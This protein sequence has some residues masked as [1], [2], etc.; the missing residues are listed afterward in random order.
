MDMPPRGVLTWNSDGTATP[1]SSVPVF[2]NLVAMTE[3]F[4]TKVQLPVP[5]VTAVQPN[6]G[7]PSGATPVT[8]TGKN[9]TGVSTTVYFGTTTG[10]WTFSVHKRHPT[11]CDQPGGVGDR[12]R[13]GHYDRGRVADQEKPTSS[14]TSAL[15]A[16]VRRSGRRLAEL[17]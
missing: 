5:S 16:S 12:Q 3:A 10:I 1:A 9:F 15:P 6:A 14:R 11:Y 2:W 8:L 13:P 7:P 17:R 4:L